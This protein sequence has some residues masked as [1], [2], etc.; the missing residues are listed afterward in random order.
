MFDSRPDTYAH[1]QQVQRLLGRMI[2][3]LLDRAEAHDQSKLASPEVELFDEFTPLLAGSTYGS[4]EYKV[5]LAQMGPALAHH[6]AHNTHHPEHYPGGIKDM[7]LLDVL[8][9]LVDWKAASL[10]HANGDFRKSLE[11]NQKRFGYS[12]ELYQIF[13]NTLPLLEETT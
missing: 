3:N 13:L 4:P 11:I 9:M 12:D 1:I 7:N 10:R 2:R 5:L 6:Y 8:E